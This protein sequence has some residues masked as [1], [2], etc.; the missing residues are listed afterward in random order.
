MGPVMFQNDKNVTLQHISRKKE[1]LRQCWPCHCPDDGQTV[2]ARC[3]IS[4]GTEAVDVDH[5]SRQGPGS[6]LADACR[7]H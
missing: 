7:A 4:E 2:F 3:W 1:A 5:G 6:V